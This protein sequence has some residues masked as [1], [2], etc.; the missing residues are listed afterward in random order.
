MKNA[1]GRGCFQTSNRV[2]YKKK[3]KIR[4]EPYCSIYCSSNGKVQEEEREEER[5]TS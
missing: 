2:S 1:G 4:T 5:K 3:L